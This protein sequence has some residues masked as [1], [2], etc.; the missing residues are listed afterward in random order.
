[1]VRLRFPSRL[2][3]VTLVVLSLSLSACASGGRLPPVPPATEV[4]ILEA[5]VAAAPTDLQAAVRLGAAYWGDGRLPDARETLERARAL[6]PGHPAPHF[7]LGLTHEDLGEHALART[8]YRAYLESGTSPRLRA[9]VQDR[10]AL[11]SR[12]EMEAAVRM[13]VAQESELAARRPDDRTLAL[14]PFLQS[15]DDPA[16][17]PLSRALTELLTSDLARIDRLTVVER[18]RVQFLLDEIALGEAGLAESISAARAGHLLGA[19]RMVQG[20]LEAEA[21]RLTVQAMVVAVPLESASPSTLSDQDALQALFDLQKRMALALIASL[22]IELTPAER[23]RITERPT[24]HLQ[25]LLAWGEGLEASDRGLFRLAA[26]HFNRAVGLDP[27]FA[28]A[29]G[30]A[31]EARAMAEA[32]QTSTRRL[33]RM[34]DADLLTEYGPEDWAR[35]QASLRAL[36]EDTPDPGG[37]SPVSE[38]TGTEGV[39]SSLRGTVEFIFRRP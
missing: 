14:L 35:L 34:D 31:E 24:E 38:T 29:A 10:L 22:G 2:P 15:A 13:A 25:A 17:H 28:E 37:R 26:D 19:G 3:G 27:G 5:R 18:V 9:A 7:F 36:A 6:D 33:A 30:H 21:D 1:M 4:P 39:G 32:E 20:R 12:R 11:L 16:F 23:E 8:H